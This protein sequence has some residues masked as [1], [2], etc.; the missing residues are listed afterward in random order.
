MTPEQ[1]IGVFDSGMGG[2]TV[3]RAL[4]ARLPSE[5]FVYLGDTARLPYGSKSADTVTRY[6]VQC[7]HALTRHGIKALLPTVYKLRGNGA[8]APVMVGLGVGNAF[9][10]F[11]AALDMAPPPSVSPSCQVSQRCPPFGLAGRNAHCGI[12]AKMAVEQIPFT[13]GQK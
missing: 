10:L 2:L 5:S 4:M 3:M 11:G 6:A 7:A 9:D 8:T 13:C 12:D 1:P